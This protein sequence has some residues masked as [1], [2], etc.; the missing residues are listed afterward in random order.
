M[1][2][3]D[4]NVIAYLFI[5]GEHSGNAK[6]LLK[7]DCDWI[8]PDLWRS[9]FRNVL[10][11]YIRNGSLSLK[12][13]SLLIKEAEELMLGHEYEV[14]SNDVLKLAAN[15]NCSAYDCEFVSLA[16]RLGLKLYTSD[17]QILK[18]FPEIAISLKEFSR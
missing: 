8:S 16:Q 2:V 9:E 10:L 14:N 12:D 3:V 7:F 13:A 6:K 17:K 15:S 4:T 1:I 11:T 18:D 5:K